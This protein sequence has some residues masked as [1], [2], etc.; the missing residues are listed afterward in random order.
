MT[1]TDKAIQAIIDYGTEQG[2]SVAYVKQ[3]APILVQIVRE[4]SGPGMQ[5]AAS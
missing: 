1:T 4:N 3:V 5:T 2:W